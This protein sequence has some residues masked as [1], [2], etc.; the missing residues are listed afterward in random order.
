MHLNHNTSRNPRGTWGPSLSRCLTLKAENRRLLKVILKS[1]AVCRESI[2]WNA[3]DVSLIKK[4]S[5]TTRRIEKICLLEF[6]KRPSWGVMLLLMHSA[7]MIF[8]L[9]SFCYNIHIRQRCCPLSSNRKGQDKKDADRIKTGRLQ[10]S[11]TAHTQKALF[12]GRQNKR[13]HSIMCVGAP[14]VLSD[15]LRPRG[16]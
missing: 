10:K 1:P 11:M 14:Y 8:L 7:I 2:K 13:Y 4:N 15:S 3:G 16:L 6:E 5:K 12:K 9:S